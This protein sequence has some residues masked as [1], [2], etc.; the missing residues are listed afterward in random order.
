MRKK[1]TPGNLPTI[2]NKLRAANCCFG[3]RAASHKCPLPGEL[4][5]LARKKESAT[6]RRKEISMRVGKVVTIYLP[7][8]TAST[9]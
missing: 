9:I 3:S 7:L 8:A 4:N 1:Y 6:A 5:E 2:K